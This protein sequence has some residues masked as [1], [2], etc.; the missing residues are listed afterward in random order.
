MPT[1]TA[2]IATT[3]IRSGRAICLLCF[4][5]AAPL[6]AGV[7]ILTNG[8]STSTAANWSLASAP[9]ASANAGS[10]QDLVFQ[11]A[12]TNNVYLAAGNLYSQSL[13]VTNGGSYTIIANNTNLNPSQSVFRPGNTPG[14]T[15]VAST[16]SIS[17]G[18]QDLFYL[19]NNSSFTIL[20][21]NLSTGDSATVPIQQAGNFN[22]STGC[23]LTINVPITGSSSKNLTLTGGGT[24][25][26]AGANTIA[27]SINITNG[28]TLFLSGVISNAS[29]NTITVYQNSLFNETTGGAIQGT[30]TLTVNSNATAILSGTNIY[31]GI[32]TVVGALQVF[33]PPALSGASTLNSGGSTGDPSTFNLATANSGYVMNVCSIGG[34]M[35]FTGPSAGSATLTFT[36]GGIFTGG[37]A[38]KKISVATNLTVVVSGTSFDLGTAATTNRD[39]TLQSD[40]QLTF[41]APLIGGNASFTAGFSKSGVGVM[42]LNAANTYNGDTKVSAGKLVLGASGSIANTTNLIVAGGATL[43]SSAL[44]GLTF[45]ASRSLLNTSNSAAATATIAGSLNAS[46]GDVTMF[47][48]NGTPAFLITNGTLTLS[49]STVINITNVGDALTAGSYKLIAR[50]TSGLTGNVSAGSLPAVNVG[51]NG[52]ASGATA[53]LSVTG[54]ELFL[55]VTGGTLYPPTIGGISSIGGGVVLNFSGTNGQ[56]W[57]ILTSTNLALPATNW[58]T[59]TTGTF[60]GS[61][62]NYTN[63]APTDAQRFYRITSP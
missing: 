34:I 37:A 50:A 2:P 7:N 38:T 4:F 1:T 18:S 16:N 29:A 9:I 13:N 44:G 53:T 12:N 10:F 52:L 48:T 43:D 62:V 11:P 22:V 5:Y 58:S 45:S 25:V 6:L 63:N 60:G 17:G 41:N 3:I 57:K 36:N 55:T 61:A 28:S 30:A 8:P 19:T 31:S 56:S 33:G 20:A 35:R 54:G 49:S 40:G 46:V 27:G 42:T 23:T 15:A 32:T 51:G 26:F 47:Y 14:N 24:N 21:G 59:V 39:H